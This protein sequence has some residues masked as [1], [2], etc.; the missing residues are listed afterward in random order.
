MLTKQE[1]QASSI[2]ALQKELSGARTE[3]HRLKIGLATKH[4]KN[5]HDADLQKKYIARI[6]TQLND[7]RK[8]APAKKTEENNEPSK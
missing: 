8:N 2:D 1:I 4:I 5:S 3:H 6:L 7:L